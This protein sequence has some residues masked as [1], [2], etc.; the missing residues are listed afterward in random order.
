MTEP[1]WLACADPQPMLEELYKRDQR[2]RDWLLVALACC[3]RISNFLSCGLAHQAISLAERRA[4]GLATN[5]EINSMDALLSQ[6][7]ETHAAPNTRGNTRI[8]CGGVA[9]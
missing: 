1:E 3:R 9:S 5:A 4:D 7:F 2:D 8:A 6:E